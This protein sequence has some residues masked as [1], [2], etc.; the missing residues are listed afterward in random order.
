[1]NWILDNVL[2]NKKGGYLMDLL[3]EK[4]FVVNKKQIINN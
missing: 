3:K 1:M 4:T 2:D